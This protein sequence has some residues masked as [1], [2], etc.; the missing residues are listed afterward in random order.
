MGT[1]SSPASPRALPPHQERARAL[2]VRRA[3][4]SA[5]QQYG[6]RCAV[7]Q[8]S[9][10]RCMRSAG[11]TT[12]RNE[13]GEAPIPSVKERGSGTRARSRAL[14]HARRDNPEPAGCRRSAGTSGRRATRLR[15]TSVEV[16]VQRRTCSLR[17]SDYCA[18][19]EN[20]RHSVKARSSR[21]GLRNDRARQR[22]RHA[23]CASPTRSTESPALSASL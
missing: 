22:A 2:S 5:R 8:S 15:R 21:H 10:R 19:L 18:V 14:C 6:A 13:G 1:R 4:K 17:R 12:R 23:W 3:A 9:T 7:L 20:C 16:R 11:S